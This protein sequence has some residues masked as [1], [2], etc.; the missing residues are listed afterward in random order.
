[1]LRRVLYKRKPVI[2]LESKRIAESER[3]PNRWYY[4]VRHGDD[5]LIPCSIQKSQVIVNFWGTLIADHPVL[6]EH[7]HSRGLSKYYQGRFWLTIE[8]SGAVDLSML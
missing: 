7:E 3:K 2:L 4:E 8:E 1:M 5:P 6:D